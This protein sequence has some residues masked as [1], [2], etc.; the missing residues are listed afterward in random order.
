MGFIHVLNKDFKSEI[1]AKVK[2]AM[3]LLNDFQTSK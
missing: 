3:I 1:A 2:L